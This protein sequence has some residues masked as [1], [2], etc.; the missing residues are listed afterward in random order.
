VW[1]VESDVSAVDLF[2]EEDEVSVVGLGYKCDFLEGIE[3]SG[4]SQCYSDAVF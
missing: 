3:I 2:G 1:S 4:F